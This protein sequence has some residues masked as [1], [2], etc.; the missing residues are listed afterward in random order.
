M[1]RV[2]SLENR[3][4]Y[5]WKAYEYTFSTICS[6]F[7]YE[8]L[9]SKTFKQRYNGHTQTF[10]DNETEYT[11]LSTYIKK[12]EEK[13]ERY[14]LKWSLKRRAATYKP[15]A[16]HCDLCLSEKV[17]ILMADPTKSLNK[18]SEILEMCRHKY[19]FKLGAVT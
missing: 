15:G 2:F 14:S 1:I 10:R 18:R 19:K 8:N 13:S 11:T 5:R 16:N 6:T 12:L 4:T 17:Q 7:F 9:T 3:A